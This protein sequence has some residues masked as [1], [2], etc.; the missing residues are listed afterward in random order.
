M[1]FTYYE[2]RYPGGH[3]E[4]RRSQSPVVDGIWNF[5]TTGAPLASGDSLYFFVYPTMTGMPVDRNG[6]DIDARLPDGRTLPRPGRYRLRM[7]AH[8]WP[9]FTNLTVGSWRSNDVKLVV[10]NPDPIGQHI[11][12]E[13]WKC[14]S[15]SGGAGGCLPA[16]LERLIHDHPD[17]SMTKYARVAVAASHQWSQPGAHNADVA[18]AI[19]DYQSILADYPD[20]FSEDVQLRLAKIY[21]FAGKHDEAQRTIV[22]LMMRHPELWTDGRFA[23]AGAV[24]GTNLDDGWSRWTERERTYGAKPIDLSQ[25]LQKTKN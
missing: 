21:H 16:T 12:N 18:R 1:L 8:I 15:F 17:H 9:E 7:V 20:F 23:W 19:G 2:I 3:L 11:L 24:I 5:T 4:R 25:Y 14:G 22:E 10:R 13:V 6:R